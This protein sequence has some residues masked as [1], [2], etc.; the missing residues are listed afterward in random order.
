VIELLGP[1]YGAKLI[2]RKPRKERVQGGL[3][4][5][6]ICDLCGL[7]GVRSNNEVELAR[8]LAQTVLG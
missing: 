4:L 2:S 8:E 6:D 1:A 5:G 3:G 7:L